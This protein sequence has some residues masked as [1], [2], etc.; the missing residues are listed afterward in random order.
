MDPTDQRPHIAFL[1]DDDLA[2]ADAIALM[3]RVIADAPPS[4]PLIVL[5][6]TGAAANAEAHRRR[7]LA[8]EA[9]LADAAPALAPARR[10]AGLTPGFP[11]IGEAQ[12]TQALTDAIALLSENEAMTGQLMV[13]TP[14]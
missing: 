12:T 2:L 3:Q 1:P 10:I 9:V 13:V 14:D 8:L 6:Y 4:T 11:A 5:G 7:K